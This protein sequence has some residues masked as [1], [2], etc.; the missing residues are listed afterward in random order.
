[1]FNEV[2]SI[3]GKPGLFKMVSQAKNY[4]IVES[5]LDQ[6]RVPSYPNEKISLLRDIVM[7]ANSGDEKLGNIFKMAFD[8]E[9]GGKITVDV[10]N[11]NALKEY[12][13]E[14]FPDFDRDRIYPNDIKKFISW[15]NLLID[16]DITDFV[17]EDIQES[18]ASE[19]KEA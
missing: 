3:A 16:N 13:G 15:Y 9:N 14:V 1:M 7:Y 8:K 19:N 5:L 2:L 18:S 10:K 4:V 11:N 12:F 6:K 17:E